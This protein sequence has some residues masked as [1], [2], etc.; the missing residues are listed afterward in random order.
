MKRYLLALALLLNH[1]LL[2][3]RANAQPADVSLTVNQ[4]DLALLSEGLGAL[5]YAKVAPLMAK[6]QGQVTEQLK[7]KTQTDQVP[8]D[9]P[10]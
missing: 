2:A 1:G 5:P 7:P 3:D 9:A 6:L 10:K 8:K 4:S